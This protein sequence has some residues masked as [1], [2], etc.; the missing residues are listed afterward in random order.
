MHFSVILIGCICLLETAAFSQP[1]AI[2]Q[3]GSPFPA[4]AL[5]AGMYVNDVEA[6][7]TVLSPGRRFECINVGLSS[8]TVSGLCGPGTNRSAN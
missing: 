6:F 1:V 7:F 4:T 2:L 3:N 8:E 5:R